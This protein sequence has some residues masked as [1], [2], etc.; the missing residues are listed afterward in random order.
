MIRNFACAVILMFAVCSIAC[1]GSNAPPKDDLTPQN[2]KKGELSSK[3]QSEV[4]SDLTPTIFE[5][6]ETLFKDSSVILESLQ[7]NKKGTLVKAVLKENDAEKCVPKAIK[8]LS[9]NF[10]GLDEISVVLSDS[11]SVYSIEMETVNEL[12]GNNSGNALLTAIWAG[13]DVDTADVATEEKDEED[14]AAETDDL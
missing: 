8:I 3:M 10:K 13:V 2:S 9:E 5:E 14:P 4:L 12:A 11:A 1:S 6:I 7:K